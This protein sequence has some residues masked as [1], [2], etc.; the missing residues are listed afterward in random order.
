MEQI[1]L[2][3]GFPK[4]SVAAIMILY[5]STKVKICSL[6]G[7]TD[8][9]DIVASV[10]HGCILAPYLFIMCLDYVLRSSIDSMKE[11]AFKL[12]KK[13]SRRYTAQTIT[14]ADNTDDKTLLANSLTWAESL[15][16]SLER[17]AGGIGLHVNA[18]KT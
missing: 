8:Y 13:R 10:M 7:D 6:D 17:A 3:N 15:L 4:E 5:K 9:F 16:H 14:D 12:A 11:N 18:D 2:T 1:F